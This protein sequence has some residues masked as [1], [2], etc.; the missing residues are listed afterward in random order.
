VITLLFVGENGAEG[1]EERG[2]TLTMQECVSE[3]PNGPDL[4]E[5]LLYLLL[6]VGR[7]EKGDK[8]AFGGVR[9]SLEEGTLGGK[10]GKRFPCLH[11]GDRTG[12]IYVLLEGLRSEASM[13]MLLSKL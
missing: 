7:S 5:G 4:E 8:G 9:D 2:G 11:R 10:G 1:F 12:R 3:E 13:R 6:C